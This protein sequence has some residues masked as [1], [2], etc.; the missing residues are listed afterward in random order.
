MTSLKWSLFS[1]ENHFRKKIGIHLKNIYLQVYHKNS[2]SQLPITQRH[3]FGVF[4]S[5]V[6]LCCSRQDIGKFVND[7]PFSC[8]CAYDYRNQLHIKWASRLMYDESIKKNQI[9]AMT[10][11]KIIQPL[12][13]AFAIWC[14]S[15]IELVIFQQSS[16]QFYIFNWKEI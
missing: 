13:L 16:N 3:F 9:V 11:E 6:N 4:L 10:K 8:R 5:V 7:F 14:L 12:L 15:K 2:N 1:Q